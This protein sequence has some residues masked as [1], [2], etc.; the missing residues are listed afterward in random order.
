MGFRLLTA[1]ALLSVRLCAADDS[2]VPIPSADDPMVMESEV[3]GE[4]EPSLSGFSTRALSEIQLWKGEIAFGLN[5]AEGNTQRFNSRFGWDSLRE[6]KWTDLKHNMTYA[7][8]NADGAEVENKF[9]HTTRQEWKLSESKWKPYWSALGTYDVF[10]TFDYRLIMNAGTA[11]QF[12]KNDTHDAQ[13]RIGS[14]VSKE[15]G[16]PDDE[17]TPEASLGG[18]WKYKLNERNSLTFGFDYF[19]AYTDF[20]DFRADTRGAWEIMVEPR[21]Q[22]G[23]R[24]G[25]LNRYQSRAGGARNNDI[26]YFAELVK[27]FGPKPPETK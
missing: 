23:L 10:Q 20:G 4:A 11:Y 2:V 21:W 22:L 3:V 1:L 19:P 18:D 12:V 25:F 15:F 14:G 6:G 17:W 13:V 5:G 7:K 16:G 9:L 27:K 24:I 26:D 8:S